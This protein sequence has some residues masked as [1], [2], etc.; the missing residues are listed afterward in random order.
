VMLEYAMVVD[1]MMYAIQ[2]FCH[3]AHT[4]PDT[5][6]NWTSSRLPFG[7]K[8]GVEKTALSFNPIK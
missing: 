2:A 5:S 6:M 4:D 7:H 1:V 3:G 8:L